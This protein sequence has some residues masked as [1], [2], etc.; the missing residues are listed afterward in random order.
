[1][2]S[3]VLKQILSGDGREEILDRI[4]QYL[5]T[6]GRE[7]RG[8]L[9]PIDKFVINKVMCHTHTYICMCRHRIDD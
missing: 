1:M 7:T 9:V 4:H 3:F 8:N 2:F 5:M 6:V